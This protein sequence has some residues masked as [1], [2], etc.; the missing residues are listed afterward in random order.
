MFYFDNASTSYPKPPNMKENLCY[1]IDNFG[2]NPGRSGHDISMKTGEKI[3][4]VRQ[5]ISEFFGSEIENVVFTNNCTDSLNIGIKGI[6]LKGDHIITTNIEHNSVLRPLFK[7]EQDGI[8]DLSI[9]DVVDK[10][11]EEIII[12]IKSNIKFNTKSII[13]N[14]GSNVIGKIM[15]ISDIGILCK[16]NNVIFIVDAAQTAGVIDIDIVKNNINILCMAGHKGL[17]G[18]PGIG[19]MIINNIN[20]ENI[21]TL[22]EG[23]TGSV[24]YDFT[25]PFFMPD[26][27][28]SGTLNTIGII[29]LECG[30]NFIKSKGINNI[31]N[32]EYSLCRYLY[33][34]LSNMDKIE[35]SVNNYYKDKYVP[36]V[37]FNVKGKSSIEVADNLNDKGFSLRGGFHCAPL[38]HK[39]LKTDKIGLVR[40]SPSTFNNMEE[41]K[42]FLSTIYNI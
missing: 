39:Y 25:H 10:T 22:K 27:F 40:F 42:C 35:L 14:H 6:I 7:L 13:I 31:Y 3:Y 4:Q 5:M 1:S 29:S 41:I 16:N 33:D 2:G 28:E 37:S 9:I 32:F 30:L 20:A 38:I 23:G 17:Y 26:R 21:K 8:I 15:P 34:E 24:S 36:I 19:I 11:D 12:D 18:C